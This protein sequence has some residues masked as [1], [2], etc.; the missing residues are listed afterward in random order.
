[1]QPTVVRVAN[2]IKWPVGRQRDIDNLREFLGL[3]ALHPN[4]RIS[5]Q[6]LSCNEKATSL[7]IDAAKENDWCLSLQTHKFVNLP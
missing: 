3:Y 4:V 6:P 7:C 5:L 2:E 1:M